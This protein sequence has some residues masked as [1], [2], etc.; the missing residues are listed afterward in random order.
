MWPL[1]S[2]VTVSVSYTHLKSTVDQEIL[3]E[4]QASGHFHNDIDAFEKNNILVC[5][6]YAV[7]Y[8]KLD[9]TGSDSYAKM[10]SDF[11]AKYPDVH[12]TSLLIPKACAFYP[13]LGYDDVLEN[14][15]A[16]IQAT[17]DSMGDEMCI[18]DRA[19]CAR[20]CPCGP[21]STGSAPGH[22]FPAGRRPAGT[23]HYAGTAAPGPPSARPPRRGQRAYAPGL[24]LIHI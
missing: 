13:P 7:E 16:F 24:S 3:P 14:Q 20:R 5:G 12:V 11:A 10:V 19:P 22:R 21:R 9:E 1:A 2:T 23:A 8:F 17:Y 6:D 18:R 4:T 15:A